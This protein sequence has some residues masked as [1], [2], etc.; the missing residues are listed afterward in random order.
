MGQN[1]RSN[2][3]LLSM[4]CKVVFYFAIVATIKMVPN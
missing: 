1:N 4:L 2:N 3:T